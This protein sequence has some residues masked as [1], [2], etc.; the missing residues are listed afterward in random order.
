MSRELEQKLLTAAA[1]AFEELAFLLPVERME[2]PQAS[3]PIDCYVSVGFKGPFSGTFILGISEE[4]LPLLAANML[5]SDTSPDEA[6]QLDALKEACNVLCGN[7]LPLAYGAKEIF[8]L[9]APERI[10][11]EEAASCPASAKISMGLDDGRC[12]MK[13]YREGE[14]A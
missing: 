13:F 10:S 5:G 7:F 4:L 9:S 6:S 3:L 11:A 12:E 8:R 14:V 1:K 2:E